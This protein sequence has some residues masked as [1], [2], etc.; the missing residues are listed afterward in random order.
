MMEKLVAM[1]EKGAITA[2]HLVA[3]SLSRLDPDNPGQVLEALP[4]G[5]L[6]RVLE[7]AEE[8]RPGKM[9]TN[10]GH[11][12]AADQVEAARRWVEERLAQLRRGSRD[13]DGHHATRPMTHL[14]L[15]DEHLATLA[16]C[17]ADTFLALDRLPYTK[18]FKVLCDRFRERTGLEIHRH[19]IWRALCNLRKANKLV[20]K[21]R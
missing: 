3:E 16:D 17:Y 8:F 19:Y 2:D 13:A 1:Y 10:Y 12:P 14:D 18:H 5:A 20:R 15:N 7:Y 21:E 4:N 6:Q 11:P 9:R